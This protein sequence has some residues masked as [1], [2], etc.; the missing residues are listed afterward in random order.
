MI[1]IGMTMMRI[2]KAT[3]F[4]NRPKFPFLLF[5]DGGDGNTGISTPA[6]AAPES[7]RLTCPTASHSWPR[8][9]RAALAARSAIYRLPRL[10]AQRR[11]HMVHAAL[12][13]ASAQTRGR[14]QIEPI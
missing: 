9:A 12:P 8:L 14:F 7:R 1:R 6:A 4:E 11:T 10:T 5:P 3:V 13:R 2:Q